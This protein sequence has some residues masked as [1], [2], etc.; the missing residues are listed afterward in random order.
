MYVLAIHSEKQHLQAVLAA[1]GTV[2]RLVNGNWELTSPPAVGLKGTWIELVPHAGAYR[3]ESSHGLKLEQT[4]LL[5]PDRDQ[6]IVFQ[7][8]STRFEITT[9]PTVESIVKV[10]NSENDSLM[11]HLEESIHCLLQW[12]QTLEEDLRFVTRMMVDTLACESAA[13]ARFDATKQA[14]RVLDASC[15]DGQSGITFDTR[16]LDTLLGNPTAHVYSSKS[17][18]TIYVPWINK[19]GKLLGAVMG[20][21]RENATN[22]E[23]WGDIAKHFSHI[24]N[25]VSK[26]EHLRSKQT[27]CQNRRRLLVESLEDNPSQAITF[28]PKADEDQ[29]HGTALVILM[30][31]HRSS[32]KQLEQV[33]AVASDVIAERQGR[34]VQYQSGV[35]RAIWKSDLEPEHAQLACAAA[36]DLI[37]R[38]SLIQADVS[39]GISSGKIS[40]HSFLGYHDY[41]GKAIRLAEHSAHVASDLELS[42]LVADSPSKS[43]LALFEQRPVCRAKLLPNEVAITLY[44]IGYP[45]DQWKEIDFKAYK[46]DGY[47][48]SPVPE[49]LSKVTAVA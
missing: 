29:R 11:P 13:I 17:L 30:Q 31:R 48:L 33:L 34:V 43:E 7:V 3:I 25:I 40:E 16:P 36:L 5:R 24:A 2:V 38:T 47:K 37:G 28:S 23:D 49:Q 21:L 27:D 39:I 42:L 22:K 18:H 10:N 46:S 15:M 6:L 44:Q 4:D 19:Q 35:F 32:H 41:S 8:G 20:R 9:M 1:K 26:R 45:G 14:W 12:N